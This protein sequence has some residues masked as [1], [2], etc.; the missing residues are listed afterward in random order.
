MSSG[1]TGDLPTDP[2]ADHANA[3]RRLHTLWSS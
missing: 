3:V 1:A 2:L